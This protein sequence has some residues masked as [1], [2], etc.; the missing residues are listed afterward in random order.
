[1]GMRMRMRMRMEMEMRFGI[2]Y[3]ILKLVHL[4]QADKLYSI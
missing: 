4:C 1:M 3:H 2:D